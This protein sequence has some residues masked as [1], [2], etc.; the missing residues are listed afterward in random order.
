MT[1]HASNPTNTSRVF[2]VKTT[3]KRRGNDRFNVEYTWC[4]CREIIRHP[5]R[6]AT[7]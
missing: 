2:H 6:T 1:F 3:W 4:A 5:A 7:Q